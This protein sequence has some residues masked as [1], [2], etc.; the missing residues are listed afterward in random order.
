MTASRC[1]EMSKWQTHTELQNGYA[2][3][4]GS[5]DTVEGCLISKGL[6][7]NF[8]SVNPYSRDFRLVL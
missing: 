4:R 5:F 3:W 7:S 6:D 8:G 1:K 2:W